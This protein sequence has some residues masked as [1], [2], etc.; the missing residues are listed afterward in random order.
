MGV[1]FVLSPAGLRV[2][3]H[4]LRGCRH[5]LDP[6]RRQRLRE[7]PSTRAQTTRGEQRPARGATAGAFAGLVVLLDG[8]VF[9]LALLVLV[10]SPYVVGTFTRWLSSVPKPSAAQLD[11]FARPFAYVSPEYLPFQPSSELGVLTD[12][13]LCHGWRASYVALQRSSTANRSRIA[14]SRSRPRKSIQPARAPLSLQRLRRRSG[15]HFIAA[16]AAPGD[17]IELYI[18]LRE[19]PARGRPY[20]RERSICI[21]K[22][23]RSAGWT[24]TE[25]SNASSPRRDSAARSSAPASPV[26]GPQFA[27]P[28]AFGHAHAA[29]ISCRMRAMRRP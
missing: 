3:V 21:E 29:A 24:E 26:L 22:L 4:C 28:S 13:Q 12:E 27:R 9:L 8:G 15:I 6:L 19:R 25:I 1:A 17:I 20:S 10:S 14:A 5:H 23:N 16:L 18:S 11:A 7:T 2:P